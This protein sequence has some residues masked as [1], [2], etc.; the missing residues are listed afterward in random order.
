LLTSNRNPFYECVDLDDIS[1]VEMLKPV[2]GLDIQGETK[3]I[4]VTLKNESDMRLF[5]NT[6]IFAQI[7][8]VN[9]E[10]IGNL[11]TDVIPFINPL[12]TDTF[13]FTRQYIVPNED[14]YYIRVFLGSVDIYPE[15]D[16]ILSLERRT[17]VGINAVA[18]T[19]FTLEQNVPNPTDNITSIGYSIPESG[20]VIFNLQ[21]ASGQ[22]L[23]TRVIQSNTGRNI[24]KLSTV[25]LASGIYLYS[26][27]YK[28]R[29][30]IK[31]LIKN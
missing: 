19:V 13:T 14:V 30:F 24:I 26:V 25:D 29:R 16:T 9:F 15:H 8:N 10:V 3:E 11:I 18:S 27:E 1:I 28:G 6:P 4:E 31:R 5:Q 2:S 23:H 22:L 20:E 12:S 7:E 21:T 17:S